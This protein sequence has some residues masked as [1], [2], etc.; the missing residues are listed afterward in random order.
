VIGDSVECQVLPLV[1]KERVHL[2]R[3]VGT[4]SQA[5]EPGDDEIDERR[6]EVVLAVVAGVVTFP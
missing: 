1:W 5:D 6:V 2:E 4:R 3:V